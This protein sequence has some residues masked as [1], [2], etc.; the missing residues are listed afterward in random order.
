M[1]P[2]FTIQPDGRIFLFQAT[3][4]GGH[5]P[6]QRA[7]DLVRDFIKTECKEIGAWARQFGRHRRAPFMWKCDTIEDG[8]VSLAVR[9]TLHLHLD[10]DT[11]VHFKL[12]WSQPKHAQG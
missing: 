4:H 7:V 11:L 12:R 8:G 1:T 5:D 6:E 10:A 9:I 3:I 2:P